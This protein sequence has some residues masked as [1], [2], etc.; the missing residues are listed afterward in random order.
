MSI[1][2]KSTWELAEGYLASSLSDEELAQLKDRLGSD[3]SFANEYH[4]SLDLIRSFEGS[5]RQK[6]FR[7]MLQDIHATQVVNAPKKKRRTII[8]PAHFWRTAAVAAGV[9]LLTSTITYS[10]LNPSIKKS[11]SQYNIIRNVVM[12]SKKV[13][14]QQQAQLNQLIQK[15]NK[16]I[17]APPALDAKYTG[18]GFALTN[19]GYFVTAYHVINDGNGDFDSVY[20]Q[21]HDGQYFKAFLVNFNAKTDVAILK[22]D[23]KNFRFSKS[24]IPYTFA[25]AKVGLGT[26][27]YTL[28]YPK[29]DIVYSKGY[30]SGRNGYNSDDEQ[31]TLELPAGHGQSGSPVIDASGNVIGLLTATGTQNEANTYAVGSAAVLDLIH[32]IPNDNSLHL[33][34]SGRLG[35]MSRTAQIDKM[36]QFTFSVKV[37]KK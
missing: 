15:V 21:N 7:S 37:Y 36:E 31:Y 24:E 25:A 19:D 33:A 30:I 22:V 13:Q 4:E 10:I 28:G 16:N 11:Q 3:A 17:P 26:D 12:D 32:T 8:L 34:K 27:I 29:D 20:I 6:R 2:N 5:G 14:A 23:K 9:A 1:Q 35:H 18:T